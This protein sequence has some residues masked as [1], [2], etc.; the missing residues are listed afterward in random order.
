MLSSEFGNFFAKSSSE[1]D[2]FFAKLSSEFDKYMYI[3]G[4]K[5]SFLHD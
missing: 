4:V 5:L 1:I 3:F 2:R